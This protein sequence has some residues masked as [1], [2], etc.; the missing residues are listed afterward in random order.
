MDH[1]P[2]DR[3]RR[4]VERLPE[5]DREL[6]TLYHFKHRDYEE[7]AAIMRLPIGT[8]KSRLNRARLQLREMLG[9]EA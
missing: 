4:A 5:A 9:E 7:I 8:A 3:I 2:S 6:V 1:E